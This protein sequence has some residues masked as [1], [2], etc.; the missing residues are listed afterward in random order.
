M[1]NV[2]LD[3]GWIERAPRIRKPR[4]RIFS[5]DYSYLR[6]DD[7]VRRFLAAARGEGENVFALYATAVYTG[8][9]AGELAGL[10]WDDVDFERRLIT[11]QRSFDGPS[12]WRG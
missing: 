2:A 9:R 10:H 12:T 6:T 5:A 1:L 7:E 3:L 4:V 8:L 11:V